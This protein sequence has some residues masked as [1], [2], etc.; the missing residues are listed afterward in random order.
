M[1]VAE[2]VGAAEEWRTI[3]GAEGFYSVSNLGR[4]RSEP[5]PG[6]T[7]GR[8]RGR[9][10]TPSLDTKG[11]AIFKLCVPGQRCDRHADAH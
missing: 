6:K 5:V 11:Y 2:A 3:S 4:V 7:V 9:I 1:V 8:K 10:L